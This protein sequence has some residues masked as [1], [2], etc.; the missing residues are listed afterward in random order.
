MEEA[1]TDCLATPEVDETPE[2]G[3]GSMASGTPTTA[4]RRGRGRPGPSSAACGCS[5][6]RVNEY[7]LSLCPY[8]MVGAP[9]PPTD[10]LRFLSLRGVWGSRPQALTHVGA[11][12][13]RGAE[14]G[15]GTND[16]GEERG[17]E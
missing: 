13:Q 5:Q 14:T 10:D 12:A 7:T 8:D 4:A 3:C 17:E 15:N 1:G 9:P 2:N 6:L 11:V 16:A